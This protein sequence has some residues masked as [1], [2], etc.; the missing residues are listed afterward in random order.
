MDLFRRYFPTLATLAGDN[1]TLLDA[2]D[3][4]LRVDQIFWIPERA[5]RDALDR[6]PGFGCVVK[7]IFHLRSTNNPAETQTERM[8][9]Q[10][11]GRRRSY[12][13]G[14]LTNT[15]HFAASPISEG[16]AV[17]FRAE[18]VIDYE[19]A[20]G[21]ARASSGVDVVQCEAHG[22]S[23]PYFVCGHLTQSEN[24]L[25]FY[26][27]EGEP[28]SRPDAWCATC[29]TELARAGSWESSDAPDAQIKLVCGGCYDALRDKHAHGPADV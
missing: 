23:G 15:P 17:W 9:V 21:S 11:T 29:N 10:L 13:H 22:P 8:W 1:W 25:G 6:K 2:E 18:H 20:D 5:D 27:A 28:S 12:Y 4:L 7:L 14:H 19:S 3:S 24:A 26:T 16:A